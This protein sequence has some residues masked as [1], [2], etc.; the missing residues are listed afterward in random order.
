MKNGYRG[1]SLFGLLIIACQKQRVG[2]AEC[3]GILLISSY[4]FGFLPDFLAKGTVVMVSETEFWQFW[5]RLGWLTR[6]KLDQPGTEQRNTNK[7]KIS[8]N[9]GNWRKNTRSEPR[10]KIILTNR[11]VLLTIFI[12]PAPRISLWVGPSDDD[13]GGNQTSKKPKNEGVCFSVHKIS[14]VNIVLI[15]DAS[16]V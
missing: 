11:I 15:N 2:D 16:K 14:N 4:F 5:Q 7:P 8:K 3:D 1:R 9:S 12:I 13:C 10:N 6:V